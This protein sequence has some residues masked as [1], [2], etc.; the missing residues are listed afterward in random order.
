MK[1]PRGARN[2]K[3]PS[4][5]IPL[6]SL[7]DENPAIRQSPFKERPEEIDQGKVELLAKNLKL[8]RAVA[9]RFYPLDRELYNPN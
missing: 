1:T 9:D 5:A 8:N 7:A 4:S 6:L 2:G 3:T